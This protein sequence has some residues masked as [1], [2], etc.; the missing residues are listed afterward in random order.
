MERKQWPKA[1]KSFAVP[2][3]GGMVHLFKTPARYYAAREYLKCPAERGPL[4]GC[5]AHLQSD[6]GESVYLIGWY[7]KRQSTLVHE[8]GHCALAALEHVGI[9]ARES[10]GEAFCYLLGT[11]ATLAGIDEF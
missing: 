6:S 5:H 11:L 7:D 10:S 9:D 4:A 3:Y 1:S 8:L 2:L